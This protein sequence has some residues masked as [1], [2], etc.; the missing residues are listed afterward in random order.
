L[1]AASL[2]AQAIR[3]LARREYARVELEQKLLAKGGEA[4]EVRALLD[5]LIAQGYLSDAR[6]A[7]VAV[8]RK[9][10]SFGRR[11]IAETLRA[12]GVARTDIDTALK[13]AGI[14]D[15]AAL[16]ALWQR[17]FGRP[18]VDARDRARQV[19]FLQARGFAVAA[20]LRLIDASRA[21]SSS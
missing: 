20:I 9:S 19:R 13:E 16:R 15:D 18:P 1:A 2:R 11:R 5:E 3:L 14:D 17:R 4:D 10:R 21:D 8:A 6:Y 7:Q 12:K